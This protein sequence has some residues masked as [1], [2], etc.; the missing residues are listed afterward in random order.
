[1]YNAKLETVID[2][3]VKRWKDVDKKTL[4]EYKA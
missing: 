1:M 4:R 3:K 2:S